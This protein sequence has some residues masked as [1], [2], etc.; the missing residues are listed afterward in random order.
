[1][2]AAV[3]TQTAAAAAAATLTAAAAAVANLTAAAAAAAATLTAAVA[4]AGATLT[5]AA[6]AAASAAAAA[7][8]VDGLLGHFFIEGS[9]LRTEDVFVDKVQPMTREV[10]HFVQKMRQLSMNII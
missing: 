4:A 10:Q 5:A 1:M 6:A 8:A 9:P 3:A 7:A 2:L